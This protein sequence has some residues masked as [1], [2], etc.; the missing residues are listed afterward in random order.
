MPRLP[1]KVS[2]IGPPQSGKSTLCKLLAQH[3]KAQVLDMEELMPLALAKL[4][5]DGLDKIKEET[6]RITIE[7]I[8][9]EMDDAQDLG[10]L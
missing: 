1:C 7:K 10:K 5:Q 3:Y 9:M 2:I 6:T 4:Q 8:K